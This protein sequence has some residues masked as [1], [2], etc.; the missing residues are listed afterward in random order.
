LVSAGL[1]HMN[2]GDLVAGRYRLLRPIGAGAMGTVWAARHELLGRDFA[3]KLT[4]IS[5]RAGADIRARFLRE[6]QIV[7]KLRHPNVVDVA[8]VGDV[9]PGTGLY[10]AM[11]LLEGQSLAERIA[12]HGPFDPP[13]ALA[14]ASEVCRGLAAAHAAGVVHRDI[15]PENIFL[16]RG[17]SG[18][19]VPKLLD[20]GISK[21]TGSGQAL[22]TLDGQLFGTPAY[23]SPEQ[24]LGEVNVDLRTDVWSLG[25]V[26]YEMLTGRRPFLAESYPAL[27]PLIADKD[28]T[29]LPDSVPADIREI[30]VRCLAKPKA[31]RF[32]SA[33]ALR[34]ALDTARGAPNGVSVH[35]DP[36]ERPRA[37]KRALGLPLP[38]SHWTL[39]AA[40]IAA[41]VVIGAIRWRSDRSARAGRP[42]AAALLAGSAASP[43]AAPSPPAPLPTASAGVSAAASASA[44]PA[45]ALPSAEAASEPALPPKTQKPAPSSRVRPPGSAKAVT[46]V[47]SAGF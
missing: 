41:A 45:G 6:A 37:R 33:D 39:I 19:I 44:A 4:S 35:S 16:A 40:G 5:P 7:G 46:K 21:A 24:A 32:P 38:S 47:N 27:L 10:L 8:D 30:I 3:L 13:E 11:E 29:P 22:I 36:I 2:E 20:F 1:L 14:V 15:K 26:L 34:Q 23:M 9:G 42:P 12:E 43:A 28:F 17:P 31:A 25:V 18:R